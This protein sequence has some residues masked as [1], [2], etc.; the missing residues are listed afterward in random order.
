MEEE[1]LVDDSGVE[2]EDL[3]DDSGVEMDDSGV[4]EAVHDIRGDVA[5]GPDDNGEVMRRV[6]FPQLEAGVPQVKDRSG[7]LNNVKV[8]ITVELGRR[9]MTV[10]ELSKLKVEDVIETDKLAGAPFE[11]RI[12]QRLFAE[13]EVVVVSELMAIRIT[14][15]EQPP[16]TEGRR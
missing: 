9:V 13:G 10:R 6:E 12:N 4:E 7:S 11:I 15:L 14:R 5:A 2:E 3:V 8:E 16:G 1:D